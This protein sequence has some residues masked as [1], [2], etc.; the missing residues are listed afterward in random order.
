[1]RTAGSFHFTLLVQNYMVSK[2]SLSLSDAPHSPRTF[3]ASV[4]EVSKNTLLLPLIDLSHA[5][6]PAQLLDS[7]MDIPTAPLGESLHFRLLCAASPED[8]LRD[9]VD[10]P[11]EDNV[12]VRCGQCDGHQRYQGWK[13]SLQ[14]RGHLVGRDDV[15]QMDRT[16]RRDVRVR[17]LGGERS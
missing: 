8:T 14:G 2:M 12:A 5:T 4:P 15:V 3:L 11:S 10:D 1:M 6:T 16:G 13:N 17:R 9:R 7:L